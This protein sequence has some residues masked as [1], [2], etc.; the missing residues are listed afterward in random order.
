MV[1]ELYIIIYH[2]ILKHMKTENVTYTNISIRAVIVYVGKKIGL[3][4]CES[5][6]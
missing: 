6:I 2:Y 3:K 5:K 1:K 4:A